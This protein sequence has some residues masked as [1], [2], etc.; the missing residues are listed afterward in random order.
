MKLAEEGGR[1]VVRKAGICNRWAAEEF[2]GR[3]RSL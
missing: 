2:V 1:D 3:K